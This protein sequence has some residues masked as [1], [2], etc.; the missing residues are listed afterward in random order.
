MYDSQTGSSWLWMSDGTAEGT[1]NIT[2]ERH[3]RMS[4]G[5]SG[6]GG[7]AQYVK[8][9]DQVLFAAFAP[10][11]G[12]ELWRTRDDPETTGLVMDIHTGDCS[13]GNFHGPCS[14]VPRFLIAFRGALFFLATDS[15]GTRV[16]RS[17]GTAEGTL[18]MAA[19][20]EPTELTK[21]G[22]SLY[23]AGYAG[24]MKRG[25]IWRSDGTSAGTHLVKHAKGW[26]ARSVGGAYRPKASLPRQLTAVGDEL[27]FRA[28]DRE[29][30]W[31]L[32]VSDG[33]GRGTRRVK[34]ITPGPEGSSVQQLTRVG[35]TL[36]F[37]VRGDLWTS[38]GSS[39]GTTLV[40]KFRGGAVELTNVG[41]R[42][43]F[44]VG[45]H[46]DSPPGGHALWV[47]DGTRSGTRMVAGFAKAPYWDSPK[48]LTAVGGVVCFGATEPEARSQLWCSDGT[49]PG[50]WRVTSHLP[51][52]EGS[53]PRELVASGNT[54]FFVT[55]AGGRAPYGSVLWK[56]VQ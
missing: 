38:D 30:G 28:H 44:A 21:A 6:P 10:D 19:G 37:T 49:V 34:D 54:L 42:L 39:A 48:E 5:G 22:G 18:P 46:S 24:P 31:E 16:Y 15:Q 40:R 36:S 47:S 9:G 33:T 32:W 25:G 3:G 29:A 20:I 26:S 51:A 14:S 7:R 53:A 12:I 50:T 4:T 23:I 35:D 1:R 52:G 2:D 13:S 8:I 11:T 41:G 27:Y 17:D 43:F 55:R 56:Y 45:P